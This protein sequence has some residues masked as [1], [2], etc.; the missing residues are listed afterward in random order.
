[1]SLQKNLDAIFD[2]E[3]SLRKA[4][5]ELLAG[6][7]HELAKL[8]K[9]AVAAAK[10]QPNRAEAELRMIRLTDLCAQ[11]P[12]PEMA[13]ALIAILDDDHPS[14]RVQAAEALVDVAYDR[15]SEV[16]R[17]VERA[18]E[19]GEQGVALRELP[20]VIAEVAEPSAVALLKRFLSHTD[21]E[22]AASAVEAMASLGDPSAVPHLEKLKN[23]TR[24]VT[25][26][27][28]DEELEATL[29]DLASEAI[30]SLAG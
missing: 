25:I 1:M 10:Q 15:Y 21:A 26:E 19:H 14:V 30:S 7:P 13:D 23:D 6:P 20:W 28:G 18:I 4:E 8:L 16:A 3:R 29:G 22:I 12:G 27:D 2:A 11:V 24:M 9:D 17:A 5:S